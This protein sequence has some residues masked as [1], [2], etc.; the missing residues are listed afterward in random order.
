MLT[1][2]RFAEICAGR[3]SYRTTEQLDRDIQDL[4]AERAELLAQLGARGKDTATGGESTL[5]PHTAHTA[6]VR[7]G[8]WGSLRLIGPTVRDLEP[9]YYGNHYRSLGGW[10][11][12]T[13]SG[14]LPRGT[15]H[16]EWA[17]VPGLVMPTG[18]NVQVGIALTRDGSR[19]MTIEWRRER[20]ASPR[21]TGRG[22]SL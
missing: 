6:E 10:L 16:M 5:A 4:L 3:S 21:A 18:I 13:L 14:E 11:P 1:A 9:D 2:D 22:R 19:Y 20:P 15:E 7:F 17:H 12:D 8:V